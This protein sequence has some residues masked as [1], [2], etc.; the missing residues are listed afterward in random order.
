MTDVSASIEIATPADKVWDILGGFDNLPLW[1]SLIRTS[2]LE[3][4]GRVRRLEAVGGAL[5]VER[6]LH[7]D[8]AARRFRYSHLEAPDPVTDYVAE[9]AVETVTATRSRVHWSASFTPVGIDEAAA[10]AHFEESTPP[11]SPN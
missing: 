9:M 4:G 7:F 3:D 5:I 6:L 11:A 2:K 10:I 8:E 1:L